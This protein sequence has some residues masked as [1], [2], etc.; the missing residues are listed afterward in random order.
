MTNTIVMPRQPS[1]WEKMMPYMMQ[2]SMINYRHKLEAETAVK[3]AKSAV[4]TW[5]A[6]KDYS[7]GVELETAQK[8]QEAD[9]QFKQ[10]KT[11]GMQAPEGM[12]LD[13]VSQ[14]FKAK[15]AK[16]TKG[17][18]RKIRYVQKGDKV[19]AQEYT[20]N[21][22]SGL[23]SDTSKEYLSPQHR[24]GAETGTL[25]EG[26]VITQFDNHALD[27]GKPELKGQLYGRYLDL[28]KGGMSREDAFNE[29]LMEQ[30]ITLTA[31]GAP[32]PVEKP[33]KD[34]SSLWK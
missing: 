18:Q 4:Q 26:S 10:S 14:T 11:E 23:E 13:P 19:Y 9:W 15:P 32:G 17:L 27:M 3:T 30:G 12:M 29:T 5:K 33:V 8:K 16:T 1:M 31:P 28:R 22:E 2:A 6:K 20:F 34:F 25:T 21:P 24:A 7:I